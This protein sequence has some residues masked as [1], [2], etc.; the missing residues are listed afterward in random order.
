MRPPVGVVWRREKLL[1]LPGITVAVV[2][3]AAPGW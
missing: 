1:L 2:G 3:G